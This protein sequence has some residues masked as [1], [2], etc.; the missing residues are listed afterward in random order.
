MNRKCWWEQCNRACVM[1]RSVERNFY[2]MTWCYP[3]LSWWKVLQA[4]ASSVDSL[5]ESCDISGL[6]D[7]EK[8]KTVKRWGITINLFRARLVCRL[9]L[10]SL[11][12]FLQDLEAS[13]VYCEIAGNR[14]KRWSILG[15]TEKRKSDQSV[16]QTEWKFTKQK[17]T[18]KRLHNKAEGKKDQKPGYSAKD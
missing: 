1:H 4:N 3:L 14:R 18:L 10:Y 7:E 2:P 16:K 15:S 12:V 6:G 8:L 13:R 9:D 11:S 17:I 5:I